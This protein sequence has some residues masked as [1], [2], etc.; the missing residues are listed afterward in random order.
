MVVDL[1]FIVRWRH[2]NGRDARC[3][4]RVFLTDPAL[5]VLT[6]YAENPVNTGIVNDFPGAAD[7]VL[8]ALPSGS[9]EPASVRWIAH[10]GAFSYF[11]SSGA[12]ETF[13]AVELTWDGAHYQGDLRAQRL[14]PSAEVETRLANLSLEPVTVVLAKLGE[15]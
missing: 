2:R 12:P 14:M 4:A 6:E 8:A 13:T 1:T 5:A 3:L 11:D 9:V 15:R 10:H 7:A